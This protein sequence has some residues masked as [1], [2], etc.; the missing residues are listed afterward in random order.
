ML[1]GEQEPAMS[2][3]RIQHVSIPRPPQSD[4]QTRAFYGDLLGLEEVPPP[5]SI[6]HLDLIWYRLG[7]TELHLFA[8]EPR[9]DTSGRHLC[10]EVDDLEGMRARLTAAGHT[11]ADTLPIPGRP[12][13]FCRDPFG[14]SIEF[15]T[16]ESDYL[17]G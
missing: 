10:I 12:R 8:E 4:Q 17:A 2:R 14:N 5:A 15:V 7:E 3:P 6:R 11:P 16:I 1:P 9:P 13:F